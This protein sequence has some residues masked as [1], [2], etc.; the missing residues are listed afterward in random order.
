MKLTT[1]ITPQT[2]LLDFIAFALNSRFSEFVPMFFLLSALIGE[3]FLQ[4]SSD[5][6][7]H[8][9]DVSPRRQP[10]EMPMWAQQPPSLC[11]Y[12]GDS[13]GVAYLAKQGIWR[14]DI[15]GEPTLNVKDQETQG[16][17]DSESG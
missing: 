10:P 16:T 13:G 9:D 17:Q 5:Q 3:E 15:T 7:G 4:I 12:T 11:S 8:Q 2:S 1:E 14:K 6:H